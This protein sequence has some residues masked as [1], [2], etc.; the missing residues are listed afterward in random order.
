[1][2]EFF[3]VFIDFDTILLLFSVLVFLASRQCGILAPRSGWI[4]Y[5]LDWKVEFL[6]TVP[7]GKSVTHCCFSG[8]FFLKAGVFQVELVVKNPPAQARRFERPGF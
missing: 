4:L 1:M 2:D 6:T 7:P 3:K 5:L 8:L